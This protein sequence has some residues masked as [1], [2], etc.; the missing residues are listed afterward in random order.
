MTASQKTAMSQQHEMHLLQPH[1]SR[2]YPKPAEPGNV[3]DEPSPSVKT[4]TDAAPPASV[5]TES[6]DSALPKDS[7]D[8]SQSDVKHSGVDSGDV[9]KDHD[10]KASESKDDSKP[11]SS[12]DD[13]FRISDEDE[14][15]RAKVEN[16]LLAVFFNFVSDDVDE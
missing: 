16:E 15:L 7:E 5:L 11:S 9:E 6:P 13:E 4:H 1:L 3:S 8:A 12:D 2:K 14:V 10:T